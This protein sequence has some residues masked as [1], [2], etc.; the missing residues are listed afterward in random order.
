MDLLHSKPV[1]G[2][3]GLYSET[4]SQKKKHLSLHQDSNPV[5]SLTPGHI[6]HTHIPHCKA[7]AHQSLIITVLLAQECFINRTINYVTFQGFLSIIPWKTI[8]V[9]SFSF[10]F[11]YQ[12]FVP[13]LLNKCGQNHMTSNLVP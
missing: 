2:S 8:Q 11:I 5:A 4:L 1:S 9:F 10:F 7:P 13:F 6:H 12:W 3:L